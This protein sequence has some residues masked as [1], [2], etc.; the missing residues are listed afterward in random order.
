[1]SM[2]QK[3]AIYLPDNGVCTGYRCC[4]AALQI[5]S[6]AVVS[7]GTLCILGRQRVV[8]AKAGNWKSDRIHKFRNRHDHIG[9]LI[10]LDQP[11][12][13]SSHKEWG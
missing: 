8:V 9:K 5:W 11:A 3:R 13:C 2:A 6:L 1:M 7:L 10:L 4:G 12:V